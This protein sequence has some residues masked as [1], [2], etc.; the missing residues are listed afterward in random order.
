MV[1]PVDR[2]IVL[3]RILTLCSF[4]SQVV[5][6]DHLEKV[7]RKTWQLAREELQRSSGLLGPSDKFSFKMSVSWCTFPNL[8]TRWQY[9][10]TAHSYKRGDVA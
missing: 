3:I 2:R 6:C 5:T 7:M 9:R 8:L 1:V 4:R 10:P